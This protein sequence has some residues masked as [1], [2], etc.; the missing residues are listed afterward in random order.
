MVS[1]ILRSF[2]VSSFNSICHSLEWSLSKIFIGGSGTPVHYAM[3]D[4]FYFQL[5]D[6]WNLLGNGSYI[7]SSEDLAAQYVVQNNVWSFF[8]NHYPTSTWA[9]V[10][11]ASNWPSN[12]VI[13]DIISP[14]AVSMVNYRQNICDAYQSIG[15]VS[16][17]YWWSN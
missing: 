12:Y 11:A 4:V 7:P 2:T 9:K 8:L 1:C 6:Q 3:H 5:T 15:L 13:F 17:N 14:E 16:P 10:N